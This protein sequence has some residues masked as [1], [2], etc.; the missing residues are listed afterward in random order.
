M[1]TNGINVQIQFMGQ[2]IISTSLQ[3]RT[4]R[5]KTDM[6]QNSG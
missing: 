1:I 5:P 6:L 2:T 3:M 4:D